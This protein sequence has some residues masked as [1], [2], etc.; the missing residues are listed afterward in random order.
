[1]VRETIVSENV[2]KARGYSHA[3]KVGNTIYVVSLIDK[4]AN[5]RANGVR[6]T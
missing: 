5:Q 4:I 1:M 6:R 3:I 2:V